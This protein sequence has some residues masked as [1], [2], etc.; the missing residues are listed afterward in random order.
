MDDKWFFGIT[1]LF[2]YGERIKVTDP[3]YPFGVFNHNTFRGREYSRVLTDL[4][5]EEYTLYQDMDNAKVHDFCGGL[6]QL[7]SHTLHEDEWKDEIV[8]FRELLALYD[9]M[10]IVARNGGNVHASY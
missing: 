7:L 1:P 2:L 8:S 10:R 9:W 5:G 4:L 3:Q 6:S